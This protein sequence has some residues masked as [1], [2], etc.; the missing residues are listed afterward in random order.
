M[1]VK[2]PGMAILCLIFLSPCVA[3]DHDRPDLN[4]WY[5]SLKNA[6]GGVCCDG[7]DAESVDDP[8]WRMTSG[9]Y[10]VLIDGRWEVVREGNLV[11]GLNLRGVAMVW[12]NS[13][14]ADP[15]IRCFMPGTTG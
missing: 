7:Q 15:R 6:Q 8:N 4:N 12:P 11:H 1:I 13:T 14:M 2:V 5:K 3:H 9:H 10:E